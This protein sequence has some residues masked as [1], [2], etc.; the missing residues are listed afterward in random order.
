MAVKPLPTDLPTYGLLSARPAATGSRA[1]FV[2]TDDSQGTTY[3]DTAAGVWTPIAGGVFPQTPGPAYNVVSTNFHKWRRAL[4]KVRAGTAN[5]RILCA[6]DSTTQGQTAAPPLAYPGQLKKLLN[7]YHVPT[8]DGAIWGPGGTNGAA[9]TRVVLGTGWGYGGSIPSWGW[10]GYGSSSGASGALSVTFAHAFD[11]IDI[12]W[13]GIQ[14]GTVTVNV[15]GGSSLGS[16][17]STFDSAYHKTSFTCTA[18][19]H[20]INITGATGGAF[21][22]YGIE[23]W[24]STSPSV[25]LSNAG[26]SSSATADW[27]GASAAGAYNQFTSYAPDLTLISLG[28]NDA[29]T[30]VADTVY[31]TNM[32]A[33]IARAQVSGDVLHMPAIPSSN[34]LVAEASYRV[35]DRQMAIDLGCGYLD[36]NARWVSYAV[37]NPLG[38][39]ND[40]LHPSQFG[41]ADWAQAAFNVLRSV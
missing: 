9:D 25:L 41:Y 30:P 5:A 22:V 33:L 15:D 13:Y 3:V 37:S 24:H 17:V 11:K 40:G 23:A 38:Y 36:M 4:S 34:R 32:R 16:I 19:T 1:I 10:G 29:G 28:V 12:W 27:S 14:T 18:G 31:D 20:T 26:S 2:A 21:N 39:Y 7:A 6:G 35:K 8:V